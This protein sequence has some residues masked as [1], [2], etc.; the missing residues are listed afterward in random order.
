[1]RNLY[2]AF[3]ARVYEGKT[4]SGIY[5]V[6]YIIFYMLFSVL[7]YGF[8]NHSIDFITIIQMMSLCG[9][10]GLFQS[11]IF[12]KHNISLKR[13]SIWA[14]INICLSILFIEYFNWFDEFGN[15]C[16]LFMYIVNIIAICM[17]F[18]AFKIS[19]NYETKRMNKA[20]QDFQSN[21]K[22]Y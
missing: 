17:F 19:I 20:L 2:Y 14:I 11:I 3:F 18:I 10:L 1:M 13:T 4:T 5:F 7:K 15:W 21:Y 9:I 8:V 22:K 12:S 6:F 16:N